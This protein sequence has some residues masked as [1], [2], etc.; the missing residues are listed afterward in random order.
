MDDLI[1]KDNCIEENILLF[2]KLAKYHG[3]NEYLKNEIEMKYAC[4]ADLIDSLS[5][6]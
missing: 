6:Y 3:E 1:Q 2:N 5:R 4:L